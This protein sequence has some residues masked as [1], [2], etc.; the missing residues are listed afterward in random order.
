MPLTLKESVTLL[1]GYNLGDFNVLTAVD[2]SRNVFIDQKISYPQDIIQFYFTQTPKE[3]PYRDSNNIVIVEFN[4]LSILLKEL[5]DFITSYRLSFEKNKKEI[6]AI[7]EYLKS[8]TIEVAERFID[9]EEFRR[10][11]LKLLKENDNYLINGFL[12]L[13]SKSIDIT[14]ERAR[15]KNAFWAYNEN[16]KILMD[17]LE[18]LNIRTMPPALVESLAYNL[19]S[20]AYYIGRSAGQSFEADET[21]KKR[22]MSLSVETRDELLNIARARQYSRIKTLL[23]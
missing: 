10:E 3:E 20:V 2:W 8:P 7:N 14:W 16:L 17:I 21:W 5:T 18:Y 12:E 1:I 9:E 19:N 15:P 6:D 11:I 13:F 22:K 4:D 23:K